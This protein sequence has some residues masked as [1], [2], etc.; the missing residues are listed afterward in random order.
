MCIEIASHKYK[1]EGVKESDP[2]KRSCR[3]VS[4]KRTKK[5]STKY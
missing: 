1:K 2:R 4:V 3:A 5:S